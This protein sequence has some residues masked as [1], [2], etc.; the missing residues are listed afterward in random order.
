MKLVLASASPRRAELLKSA[1]IAFEVHAADV[2]ETVLPG[3]E[4]EE[5]ISRLSRQKA[6]VIFKNFPDS[7]VLAADT[8]V[9]FDGEIFGK[10]AGPGQAA[11]MLGCLSGD[12]HEVM[13]GFT[14]LQPDS[15]PVSQVVI[16]KVHFRELSGEEIQKYVASGEPMDKAGA[17]GI[18]AGAAHMVETIEG[19]YTNIVGLPLAEVVTLLKS[20]TTTS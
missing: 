12:V 1:G 3:E 16:S 9:V 17:Y 13:T 7:A 20:K 14:L 18:Q 11:E 2:D 5:L 15:V 8:V 10:P 4:P 19:S 6:E